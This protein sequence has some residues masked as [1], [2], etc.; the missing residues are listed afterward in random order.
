MTNTYR[1]L[2]F[3]RSLPRTARIRKLAA[4]LLVFVLAGPAAPA[5]ADG[6]AFSFQDVEQAAKNL[7]AAPFVPPPAVAE[8]LQKLDYDTWRKIRFKT[9]QAYWRK[10]KLPFELQFFHPGFLYDRT[11]KLN[12]I[13]GGKV[14]PLVVTKDMFDYSQVKDLEGQLP[15]EIGAAGFR[16][17][18]AINTSSYLDEFAVFLGASYFR[19]VAKGQVYGLSARGLA[20]NTAQQPGEEFPWF[21]EFWIE[22]PAKGQKTLTVYA[23]LDSQSLAGAYAFTLVP[24]GETVMDVTS[25]LYLRTPVTTLGIAPLTSMFLY[26]EN[27]LPN[28]RMD[29]RPEIHDSDGLLVRFQTGEWL[30]RP[31]QNPA[32]S[33]LTN[34]FAADNVRGFGLLNRDTDFANY[35]DT[36]ARYEKRPSLWIEPRGDWGPGRVDLLLIPSDQEIHDN[37][38]AFFS[39]NEQAKPGTPMAFDYRM[40]W[41]TAPAD[42]PPGVMT[43]ATR[44]SQPDKNSRLFV[45]D[46]MG[47]K[48]K[49]LKK[50]DD[51]EAVVSVGE[52]ATLL[53]QQ[54]FKNP[55]TGGY[56]LTFKIGLDGGSTLQDIL[57]EKRGPIELRAFLK[58][59][60]KS[61]SETWTYSVVP[62]KS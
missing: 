22:K 9:D 56:R 38:V 33:L 25:R 13:D 10:A 15:P 4:V 35:Q 28:A 49:A 14:A 8:P 51:A 47:E 44:S 16:V 59:A 54:C 37:V 52:G 32:T 19:A 7:A 6:K 2:P 46:F 61:V 29:W 62:G 23:L 26:G 45:V 60:D 41:L 57:P 42:L 3:F 18:T 27:S 21:R 48:L 50:D 58:F 1:F 5:R 36:E 34:S 30:W 53:E 40:R 24:G 43:V 11:V 20:V 55:V 39:P 31:A 17:H 12:V